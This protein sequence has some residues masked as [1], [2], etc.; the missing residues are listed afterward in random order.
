[1]CRYHTKLSFSAF[2]RD[3]PFSGRARRAERVRI[4]GSSGIPIFA[5]RKK[6]DIADDAVPMRTAQIGI[7]QNEFN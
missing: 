5:F 1:M 7:A 3:C 4:S 2:S 6:R